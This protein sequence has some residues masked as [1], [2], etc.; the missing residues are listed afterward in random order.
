MGHDAVHGHLE[1]VQEYNGAE[2]TVPGPQ[3]D[4]ADPLGLCPQGTEGRWLCG[5]QFCAQGN[6]TQE[7]VCLGCKMLK[8]TR[9]VG[10]RV[11]HCI[12]PTEEVTVV[13][14]E[15]TRVVSPPTTA[16]ETPEI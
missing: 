1:H 9:G 16:E 4:T 8:G 13:V 7:Q 6:W 2:N 11:L 10:G 3:G 14:E 15:G 5:R 12:E